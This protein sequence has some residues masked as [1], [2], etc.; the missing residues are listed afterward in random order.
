MVAAGKHLLQRKAYNRVD[1]LA[2]DTV[3]KFV[4]FDPDF[5][6]TQFFFDTTEVL[7]FGLLW[8]EFKMPSRKAMVIVCFVVGNFSYWYLKPKITPITAKKLL[9]Y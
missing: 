8:W 9:F 1:I 2:K 5:L 7:T 4:N 6:K 3:Q